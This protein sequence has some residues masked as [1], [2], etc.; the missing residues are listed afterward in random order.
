MGVDLVADRSR[1]GG[2]GGLG[3]LLDLDVGGVAAVARELEHD[4]ARSMAGLTLP[5]QIDVVPAPHAPVPRDMLGSTLPETTW[6]PA[7]ARV[8]QQS[9]RI[10]AG[11]P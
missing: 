10:S 6:L 2:R 9:T 7:K 5:L 4:T 11:G 3:E 8:A 1:V